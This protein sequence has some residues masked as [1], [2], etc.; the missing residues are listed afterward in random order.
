MPT[1]TA[2]GPAVG[3]AMLGS[4]IASARSNAQHLPLAVNHLLAA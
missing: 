2:G 1:T 4:M 3:V